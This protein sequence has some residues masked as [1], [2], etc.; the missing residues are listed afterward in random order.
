M[1]EVKIAKTL[2]VEISICEGKCGGRCNFLEIN[3]RY[4]FM[5][6]FPFIHVTISFDCHLFN[7]KWKPK[8]SGNLIKG[9]N[10][11]TSYRCEECIQHFGKGE[12]NEEK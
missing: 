11:F 8:K 10:G 1:S 6:P 4:R 9:R 12:K 5:R 3:R 2:M 7:P